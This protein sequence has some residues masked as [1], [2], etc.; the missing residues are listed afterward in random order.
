MNSSVYIWEYIPRCKQREASLAA[1]GSP[2][3]HG[4]TQRWRNWN[5]WF[6]SDNL[7]DNNLSL[8]DANKCL[9]E[10]AARKQHNFAHSGEQNTNHPITVNSS[11]HIDIKQGLTRHRPMAHPVMFRYLSDSTTLAEHAVH[12]LRRCPAFGR[13]G[14]CLFSSV[15]TSRPW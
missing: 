14:T 2:T 11:S 7:T 8:F 12:R 5:H 6:L 15:L 10:L 4:G 3:D 1:V 13:A 9:L